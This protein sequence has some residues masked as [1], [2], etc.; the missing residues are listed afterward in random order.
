LDGRRDACGLSAC[1]FH[2]LSADLD[3]SEQANQTQ[4]SVHPDLLL[5][6]M[7]RLSSIVGSKTMLFL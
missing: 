1:V 4:P 6:E 3:G 5:D 2:D 7:G